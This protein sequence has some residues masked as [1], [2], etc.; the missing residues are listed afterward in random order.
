MPA[1]QLLRNR[2]KTVME[3][4]ERRK[5]AGRL[6]QHFE[7]LGQQGKEQRMLD[8]VLPIERQFTDLFPNPRAGRLG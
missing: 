8:P 7:E 3:H 2:K 5:D 1:R 4:R 6:R